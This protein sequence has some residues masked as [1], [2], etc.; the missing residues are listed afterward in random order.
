MTANVAQA[1]KL[2]NVSE[3]MIYM[4]RELIRR[5]LINA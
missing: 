2:M 3:R 1:G 5:V 4:C